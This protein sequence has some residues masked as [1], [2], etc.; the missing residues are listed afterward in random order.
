M[1]T[2]YTYQDWERTEAVKRPEVLLKM[3]EAYK[4]SGDFALALTAGRYFRGENDEVMNKCILRKGTYTYTG[5]DGKERTVANDIPV[6]GNRV[7]SNY[8]FRFVTQQNQ[9][10]L[11]NGVSLESDEIKN[12]L[13]AGFDK[14][15]EH[16]GEKSLIQG[17]CWAYWNNGRVEVLE[18]ARDENSGFFAVVDEAD[19]RPRMGVQF[20][21][22]D[23]SRPMYIRLFEE[24]GV[25]MY[26][27][28]KN[29]AQETEQKRPYIL[30]VARDAAG[31]TITGGANYKAL[32]IIPLYANGER[33]SE[34]S[35]SIKAKID[36]YD[37]ISSD[38]VDNL[39]KANDVMWVLNNFG[40]SK[41]ELLEMV[42]TIRETGIIANMSDGMGGNAS[43][44]PKAFEVPYAARKTALE[45]LDREL[46]KDY[47]ALSMDELTGGS[48]TNVAIRTATANLELKA[49]R[50]EWQIFDFVQRLLRFLGIDTEVIKFRRQTISN[51][52]ETV[53]DIYTMRNDI[54]RRTALRLNPYIAEDEIDAIMLAVD[55]DEIA[56][57]DIEVPE[58]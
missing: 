4:H 37:R 17:V 13:G 31:E 41:R 7:P 54:D 15:L 8:F 38:F 44:E 56:G 3:I 10:L 26:K 2:K 34:L 51:E 48:L 47:M 43:A 32:P 29:K 58:V 11:S 28:E 49:D 20:W 24:D 6:V 5:K 23:S 30:R 40:G 27:A 52:S 36:A 19:S 18:A 45:I 1:F 14:T 50:Y 9:Y 46:Y 12:R 53:A 57:A 55:K 25:T 35:P 21:R 22:I 16:M 42:N 39:D 33:R